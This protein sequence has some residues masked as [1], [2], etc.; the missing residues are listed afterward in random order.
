MQLPPAIIFINADL[1]D[2]SKATLRSQLYIN[3]IITGAQFDDVI[4]VDPTFPDQVHLNGAR[5]LVI[6]DE[7]YPYPNYELAD[8]VIFLKQGLASI[9][10][11]K[12]G[13]PGLT[14]P[15]EKLNIYA[16]LRGAGSQYV[17]ILPQLPCGPR[18]HCGCYCH[19]PHPGYRGI[20]GIEWYAT[21]NTGVHCNNSD[22]IYNN[23][24][25]LNRK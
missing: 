12:L 2:T 7:F 25:F 10:K 3:Q 1:N 4:A 9:E 22:N 15:L 20:I 19:Y 17:V 18:Y 8:V 24:A 13:P 11:N 21:D 14:L 23:E 5:I 16:L 6:R